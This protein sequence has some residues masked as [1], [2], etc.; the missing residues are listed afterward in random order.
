MEEYIKNYTDKFKEFGNLSID[1]K[2]RGKQNYGIHIYGS[3]LF[4]RELNLSYKINRY[5]CCNREHVVRILDAI[6]KEEL[7]K[8]IYE[9]IK[10]WNGRFIPLE[11]LDKLYSN[12]IGDLLVSLNLLNRETKRIYV[13]DFQFDESEEYIDKFQALYDFVSDVYME[14]SMF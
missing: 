1:V 5:V 3:L 6:Y 2:N 13:I 8:F 12:L 9:C 10:F 14:T 11:K 7:K 4:I